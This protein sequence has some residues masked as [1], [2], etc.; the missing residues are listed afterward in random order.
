MQK[1][2]SPCAIGWFLKLC[3]K[4]LSL[5]VVE[6]KAL[7]DPQSLRFGDQLEQEVEQHKKLVSQGLRPAVGSTVYVPCLN[8]SLKV[9]HVCS[10][11]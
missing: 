4:P 6:W 5:C 10:C 9:C 1:M 7:P 3:C 11:K 2:A 8:A